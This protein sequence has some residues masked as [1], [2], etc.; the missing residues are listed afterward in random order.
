MERSPGTSGGGDPRRNVMGLEFRMTFA[1]EIPPALPV[2]RLHRAA[3]FPMAA[4]ALGKIAQQMGLTGQPGEL[5]ISDDWTTHREGLHD[6]SMHNRSGAL[7]YMHKERYA[8]QGEKPFALSDREA[9]GA[10]ERFLERAGLVA[11]D[12][13]R[14]AGVTHLRTAGASMD[15]EQRKRSPEVLLDAGVVYRRI[16]HQVMVDGPGGL[17]MIHIDPDGEVSGFHVIWRPMAEAIDEV[18]ILPPDHAFTA[19]KEIAG[20]VRGDVE[21][22]K[23]S[24]GYFEQGPADAQDYLQPAYAM[25][26]VVR[27]GEVAYKSAEVVPAGDRSYEPLRGEK[28]FPT[29]AQSPRKAPK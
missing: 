27:D 15:G 25:V 23:A 1:K 5:C 24:F 28:R 7:R 12:E 6:L 19:M 29:R 8:Q 21:V 20:R 26:Y 4:A 11:R 9:E 2:F 14:P 10:A 17:A 22:T 18:K 16:V 13:R 3:G